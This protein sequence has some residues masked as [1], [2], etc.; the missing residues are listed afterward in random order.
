VLVQRAELELARAG[1]HTFDHLVDFPG[2]DY[3]A[4][5]GETEVAPG[6]AL[7]PTPGHTAGHQ[8][9][10]VETAAGGVLLAGQTHDAASGWTADVEA[11]RRPD[12]ALAPPPPWL[13]AVLDRVVE[14]RF[15]HDAAIW[16]A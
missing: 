13:A 5:D 1:G 15:A 12:P 14:A 10:L 8:S 2:V 11:V 3:R 9:L 6:V 7:I 4:L 16:R